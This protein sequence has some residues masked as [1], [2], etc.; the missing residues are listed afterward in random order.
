M[1]VVYEAANGAKMPNK[2]Q[3][4]LQ[5][6]TNEYV[7]L[8]VVA[9]VSDVNKP[10]MSVMKACR[11]GNQVVFDEEGSYIRHKE[12]GV[13]TKIRQEGGK[14]LLPMWVPTKLSGFTRQG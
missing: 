2:G 1:G 4:T 14:Y 11:A 10:L 12:S 5:G 3:K 6:F 13:I 8:A 9:Q 7:P